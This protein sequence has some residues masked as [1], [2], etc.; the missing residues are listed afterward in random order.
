MH[1]PSLKTKLESEPCYVRPKV[2]F[3]KWIKKGLKY[4]KLN[5]KHII[6]VKQT[7]LAMQE[8]IGIGQ[9]WV[10]ISTLQV[11]GK[12]T[13]KLLLQKSFSYINPYRNQHE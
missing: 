4:L 9:S 8:A 7:I 6:Y 2:N 3:F 12:L 13:L 10:D 1:A 11:P 5:I